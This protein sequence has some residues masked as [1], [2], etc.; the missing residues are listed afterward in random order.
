MCCAG[1]PGAGMKPVSLPSLQ[2][3]LQEK[4]A[5]AELSKRD[6]LSSAM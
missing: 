1:R 6:V 2:R 5:G 3:D 4:Y